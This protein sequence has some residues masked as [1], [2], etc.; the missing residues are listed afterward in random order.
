MKTLIAV[1]CFA[2][3]A[4]AQ[5]GFLVDSPARTATVEVHL[6]Y[7]LP[8]DDPFVIAGKTDP[9]QAPAKIAWFFGDEKPGTKQR[10]Y[11][12]QQWSAPSTITHSYPPGK[13]AVMV[14]IVDQKGRLV[15]EDGIEI[16]VSVPVK[17]VTPTQ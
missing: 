16:E 4:L 17:R 10:N 1:F 7:S 15:K 11:K 6:S 3:S 13:Y 2:L 5:S 12:E 8:S 14:V 9:K